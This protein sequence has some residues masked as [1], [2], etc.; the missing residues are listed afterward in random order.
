MPDYVTLRIVDELY[1]RP[2]AGVPTRL[3][4][5]ADG[6]RAA[7]PV[8]TDETGRCAFP[9]AGAGPFHLV[10]DLDPYFA[11]LGVA[12]ACL[13]LRLSWRGPAAVRI[14]IAPHGHTVY[15]GQ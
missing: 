10:V 11:A 13:E 14:Q 5:G 8:E 3:H 12:A 7:M 2:A 4:S 9:V 1:G 15:I 6:E